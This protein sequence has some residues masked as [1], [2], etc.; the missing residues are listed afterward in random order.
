MIDLGSDLSLVIAAAGAVMIVAVIGGL[1]TGVGPWCESLAFPAWR[2]PNWL[3][4]PAW[5]LTSCL[6][7]Q[8]A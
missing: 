8:A 7:P 4:G 5:T 3:F 6:S 2:P 1:T